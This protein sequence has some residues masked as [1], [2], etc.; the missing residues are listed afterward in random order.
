MA[1]YRFD[2]MRV[3]IVDDNKHMRHL[4]NT[5]LQA[6][7]FEKIYEACNAQD[8]WKLLSDVK[9]DV[10][11]VDWIMEPIN[12]LQ[13]VRRVRRGKDS[14]NPYLNIIMMSGLANPGAVHAARDA[15]VNEY[16]AKPLSAEKI[17][18]RLQAIIESP[19]PFVRTKSYFGPD[20]RRGLKASYD[21]PER[22]AENLN[23]V[24]QA[25][26]AVG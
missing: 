7:G 3:L 26:A 12:G 4:V 18:Q 15:G 14:P 16:L 17:Y 21:G 9:P 24:P 25:R 11:F 20:R 23:D 2:R 5:I 8:A 13:F 10:V 19:R 1:S 6:F 22:R